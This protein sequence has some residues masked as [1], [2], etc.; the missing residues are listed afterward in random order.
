MPAAGD[1][2]SG[3]FPVPSWFMASSFT[4]P[5][6]FSAFDSA[7][8]PSSTFGSKGRRWQE[9]V[10]PDAM[11]EGPLDFYPLARAPLGD[12]ITLQELS[13]LVVVSA[14]TNDVRTSVAAVSTPFR[15]KTWVSDIYHFTA[16]SSGALLDDSRDIA[17]LCSA[18]VLAS[19]Q[20]ARGV[21]EDHARD[22]SHRVSSVWLF[23]EAHERGLLSVSVQ[24]Y[25][26]DEHFRI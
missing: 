13:H 2:R 25:R 4:T 26:A 1:S 21:R 10:G 22:S 14:T 19:G 6:A 16:H 7:L 5:D 9:Q 8:L 20:P 12:E 3:A 11:D 18:G 17:R 23:T 15:P 24:A